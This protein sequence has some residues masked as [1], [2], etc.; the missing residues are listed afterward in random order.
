VGLAAKLE[1]YLRL[2]LRR[3][4]MDEF[5][6]VVCAGLGLLGLKLAVVLACLNAAKKAD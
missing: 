5:T 4:K 1:L 3:T 6:L 2:N